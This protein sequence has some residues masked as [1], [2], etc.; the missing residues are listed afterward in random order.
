MIEPRNVIDERGQTIVRPGWCR[1]NVNKQVGRI[2]HVF[3]WTVGEQLIPPSVY[4]AL[5]AVEGLRRGRSDAR[6]T[7]PVKPVPEAHVLAVLPLVSRQVRA[8]T[9]LQMIT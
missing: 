3:K 7:E 9:E 6:E 4:Q 1:S 8:I 2:K 5:S